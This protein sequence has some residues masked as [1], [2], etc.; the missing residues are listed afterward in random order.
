M[1]VMATTFDFLG[2][3]RAE[4][5]ADGSALILIVEGDKL[6]EMQAKL[7]A[8]A[9]KSL[10]STVFGT[11]IFRDEDA[12]LCSVVP[13]DAG[14]YAG[15]NRFDGQIDA[16]KFSGA[17]LP[18][19]AGPLVV[20]RAEEW[21]KLT[22]ADKMA[23]QA[24]F[25][26]VLQDCPTQGPVPVYVKPDAVLWRKAPAAE[27]VGGRKGVL[28][29]N[30]VLHPELTVK[31]IRQRR[32][33][34]LKSGSSGKRFEGDTVAQDRPTVPSTTRIP[35]LIVLLRCS[36]VLLRYTTSRSASLINVMI[37]TRYLPCACRTSKKSSRGHLAP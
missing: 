8:Y 9:E 16:T 11:G 14:P 15:V 1:P 37:D 5:S 26:D 24:Q 13:H 31:A 4:E 25:N 28:Y 29:L 34:V 21:G 12:V 23:L 35:A 2:Y 33:A 6:Q 7:L 27:V 30:F 3:S 22:D 20:S 19:A 17:R 32:S 18:V 36:L 10:P